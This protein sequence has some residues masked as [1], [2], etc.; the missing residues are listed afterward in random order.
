MY[1][2]AYS[3]LREILDDEQLNDYIFNET[4]KH[5]AI[6]DAGA[7]VTTPAAKISFGGGEISASDNTSQVAG[8]RVEFALP[9]WGEDALEQCHSFLDVAVNA[10]FEHE[11][12]NNPI[13]I[14]RVTRINP[15]ITELDGDSDFWTVAFD[16]TV[17]VFF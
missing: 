13:R 4:G 17:S 8:Y 10:F 2:E 1:S 11:Q 7:Q 16:V 5:L 3:L 9:F 14:N 15:S 6:I 12:R